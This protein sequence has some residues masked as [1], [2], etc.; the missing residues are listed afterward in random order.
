M[1]LYNQNKWVGVVPQGIEEMCSHDW[2]WRFNR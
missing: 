2:V 1:I